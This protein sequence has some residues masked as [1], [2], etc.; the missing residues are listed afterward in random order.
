MK[1]ELFAYDM[2]NNLTYIGIPVKNGEEYIRV[3]DEFT[4]DEN[5]ELPYAPFFIKCIAI[6]KTTSKLKLNQLTDILSKK[7]L[8]SVILNQ[9][10]I[11]A[12]YKIQECD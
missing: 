6:K 7:D 3:M 12:V 10:K 5:D 11:V 9:D 8:E 2:I 1:K 4:S